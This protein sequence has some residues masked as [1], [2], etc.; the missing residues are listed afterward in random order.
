MPRL[1]PKETL[2]LD[3][4]IERGEM[5]GLQL[6]SASRRRLK[7]GTVYVTLGRMEDK[8][9]VTSRQTP[10]APEAGGLPRRLYEATPFGYAC[11]APGTPRWH[12]CG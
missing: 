4:L 2:V 12:I 9:Y 3:L 10:P 11:T 6:V 7:R 5:Y 1:S 8:G